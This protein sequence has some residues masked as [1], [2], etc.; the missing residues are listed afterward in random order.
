[1]CL[2]DG[3]TRLIDGSA[4]YML[5][6]TPMQTDDARIDVYIIASSD[7]SHQQVV[8]NNSIH[9]RGESELARSFGAALQL[10]SCARSSLHVPREYKRRLIDG[11]AMYMLTATP[12]KNYCVHLC[13][14]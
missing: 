8:R 4:M 2:R 12:C 14:V 9:H 11:S 3:K 5:T 10:M 6:A 7:A 1:M 13:V